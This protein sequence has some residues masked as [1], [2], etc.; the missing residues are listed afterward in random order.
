MFTMVPLRCR[1]G[2]S[3]CTFNGARVRWPFVENERMTQG[4]LEAAAEQGLQIGRDLKAGSVR[5]SGDRAGHHHP[6]EPDPYGRK[7][8]KTV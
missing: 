6:A 5:S 3:L 1:M 2:K 7:S 4:V 8:G